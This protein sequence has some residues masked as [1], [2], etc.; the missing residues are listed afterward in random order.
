MS[1]LPKQNGGAIR[2]PSEYY[3]VDSGRYTA[4]ANVGRSPSCYGYVGQSGGK[5]PNYKLFLPDNIEDRTN[6]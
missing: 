2:M 6:G 3:G 1:F 5:R 4:D